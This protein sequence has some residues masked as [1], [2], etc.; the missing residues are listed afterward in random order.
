[1][2]EQIPSVPVDWADGKMGFGMYLNISIGLLMSFDFVALK[3]IQGIS[4]AKKG[5]FLS[6]S[7]LFYFVY[8][9][10]FFKNAA[11][12]LFSG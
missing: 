11:V 2:S 3:K 4:L 9:F 10:F 5:D 1:M 6:F 7:V 12:R 8:F